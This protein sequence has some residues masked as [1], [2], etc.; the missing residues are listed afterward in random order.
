MRFVFSGWTAFDHSQV[1]IG[2][3]RPVSLGGFSSIP[4][5]MNR[6]LLGGRSRGHSKTHGV[7]AVIN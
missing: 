1:E 3:S 2:S 7:S 6:L 5:K 4:L